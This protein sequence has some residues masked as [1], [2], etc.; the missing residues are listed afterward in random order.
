[1]PNIIVHIVLMRDDFEDDICI[2]Y[3]A[4]TAHANKQ[5]S[6]LLLLSRNDALGAC[7]NCAHDSLSVRTLILK[8]GRVAT[9]AGDC[10]VS[11]TCR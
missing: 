1:M 2:P 4:S 10:H 7:Q 3:R 8:L 11:P 5:E 9:A 6:L